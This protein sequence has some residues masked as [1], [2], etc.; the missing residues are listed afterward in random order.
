MGP[1][2]R[3]LD[4]NDKRKARAKKW[5]EYFVVACVISTIFIGINMLHYRCQTDN[6]AACAMFGRKSK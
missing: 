5:A 3:D 4:D 6:W 1:P 2:K